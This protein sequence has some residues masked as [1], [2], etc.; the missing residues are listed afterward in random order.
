MASPS[1]YADKYISIIRG[2][3]GIRN[4]FINKKTADFRRQNIICMF[5]DRLHNYGFKLILA[6]IVCGNLL[7]IIIANRLNKSN[8]DKGQ[9][10]GKIPESLG[11]VRQFAHRVY[12]VVGKCQEFDDNFHQNFGDFRKEGLQQNNDDQQ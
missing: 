4:I 1:D 2:P 12:G 9:D 3:K 11:S 8:M 10:S 6:P 7:L 5:L